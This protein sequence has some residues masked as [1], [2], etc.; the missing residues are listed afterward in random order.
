MM[1]W[2][3]EYDKRVA[4]DVSKL[5]ASVKTQI[6]K[7]I[8]RVSKNPLPQSEGGYGKPLGNNQSSKLAGCLKIK[9]KSSGLRVVY[10]LVR[11]ETIMKII[12][13]SI[14]D[15]DEIYKEADKRLR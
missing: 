5:D 8:R 10:K 6:A 7:M 12:I 3:I 15:D 2:V 13:I 11:D 9:L 14:R 1:R 4:K